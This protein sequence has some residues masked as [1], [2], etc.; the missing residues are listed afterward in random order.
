MFRV[1]ALWR[2]LGTGSEGQ[3][4][5]RSAPVSEVLFSELEEGCGLHE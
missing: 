1:T 2:N 5:A 4:R 3:E